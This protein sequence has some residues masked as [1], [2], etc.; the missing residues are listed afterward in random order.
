LKQKNSALTKE[1]TSALP[2]ERNTAI[3][4]EKKSAMLKSKRG[5][6]TVDD[7]GGDISTAATDVR[8]HV[9]RLVLIF[10]IDATRR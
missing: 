6:D 8:S 5:D 3:Y 7:I 2:N 1:K 4:N 9:S 10:S